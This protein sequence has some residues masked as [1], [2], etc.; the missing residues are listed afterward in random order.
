MQG[1]TAVALH[2]RAFGRN[3]LEAID[4]RA[5]PV[6]VL[7]VRWARTARSLSRSMCRGEDRRCIESPCAMI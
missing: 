7:I 2:R 1:V 4:N 6:L 5:Q 3:V